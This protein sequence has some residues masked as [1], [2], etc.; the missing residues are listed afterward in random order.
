MAIFF[1]NLLS[2]LRKRLLLKRE[3]EEWTE[4]FKD[5]FKSSETNSG[6]LMNDIFKS[7]RL[8]K[9]LLVKYHPDLILD[10]DQKQVADDLCKEINKNKRNYKRLKELETECKNRLF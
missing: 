10:T 1:S 7:A 3:K 6:D 4:N 2:G 8:H 9:E 5:K